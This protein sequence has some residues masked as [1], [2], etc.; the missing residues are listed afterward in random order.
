M[1]G[2][3]RSISLRLMKLTPVAAPVRSC[4]RFEVFHGDL[5]QYMMEMA[6]V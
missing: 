5:F 6:A 3:V 2:T 4:A 1:G